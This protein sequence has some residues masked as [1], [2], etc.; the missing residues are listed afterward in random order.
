MANLHD[1][2]N[3]VGRRISAARER[4]RLSQTDVAVRTNGLVPA[5]TLSKYEHGER[6]PRNTHIKALAKA[7]W[8]DVAELVQ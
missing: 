3:R 4:L 8:L 2:N 1:K 5:S 7:L 6:L